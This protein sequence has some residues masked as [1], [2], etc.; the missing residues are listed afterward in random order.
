MNDLLPRT[1][2]ASILGYRNAALRKIEEGI[3]LIEQGHLLA[4]EAQ[5]LARLG[6]GGTSFHLRRRDETDTYRRIFEPFNAEASR[7]VYKEHLDACIWMHLIRLTG[8]DD[9]MDR[10]E[11]DKLYDSLCSD[12]G[13]PEATE[14]NIEATFQRLAQD[15]RLIFQRGLARAFSELD[16]RFKSHDAFKLGDRIILTHVFDSSGSWNYYSRMFDTLADIERVFAVLDGH[17]PKIGTLREAISRDRGNGW[18]PRQSITQSDYFKVR[19]FKNGNAHLWF[20]RDDLVEKAN[21]TLAEYYGEVLP[22]AV[23]RDPSGTSPEDLRSKSGALSKDLSFYPTPDHVVKQILGNLYI[24]EGARIL[25]PSAGTGNI[26]R[27]LLQ[28]RAKVVDAI[29]ID[30]DRV[31]V[32]RSIRDPRLTVT[33]ANF[34]QTRPVPTY[35]IVVMNPPFYGTHWMEHVMHAYDFLAPGGTLVS[36][37]PVSA[38]L[39]QT[40]K[41]EEFRKWVKEKTSWHHPFHDLPPESFASSG[42]RVN[43]VYLTLHKSNRA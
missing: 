6:H 42:T 25:E 12:G 38:E 13:V 16:R 2:V 10:T 41:H 24:G 30:P 3:S 14:E 37:L 39:G 35:D 22:D 27:H 26:V 21:L 15:A 32:L 40:K 1:T 9:L 4:E 8:L 19:T 11:K 33:Q 28:T 23:P 17:R 7:K 34:L 36:V 31:A 43:T 5:D 18:G 29:E 20:T